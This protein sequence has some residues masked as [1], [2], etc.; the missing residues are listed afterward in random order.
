M[1]DAAVTW[2]GI[3]IENALHERVE[4]KVGNVTKSNPKYPLARLLHPS[5]RLPRPVVQPENDPNPWA[6]FFGWAG[7]K[8]SMMKRY[9]YVKPAEEK[10]M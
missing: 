10:V 6:V 4:I 8:N 2:F 7:K 9:A 3:T 1:F 5:F